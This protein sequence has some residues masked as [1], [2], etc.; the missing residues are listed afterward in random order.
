LKD[1]EAPM[2]HGFKALEADATMESVAK[3]LGV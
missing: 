3:A 1:P 2:V